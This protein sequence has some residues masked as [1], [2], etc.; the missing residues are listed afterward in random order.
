[1]DVPAIVLCSYL[2]RMHR[3]SGH[4]R[5][6]VSAG[7]VHTD[8]LPERAVAEMEK[9]QRHQIHLGAA[10]KPVIGISRVS[11]LQDRVFTSPPT[12]EIHRTPANSPS[13]SMRFQTRTLCDQWI[14]R[15]IVEV[16]RATP[17][18][19]RPGARP[20]CR[21]TAGRAES[22]IECM[23]ECH[24]SVGVIHFRQRTTRRRGAEGSAWRRLR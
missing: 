7:Q 8:L 9:L 17:H 16:G 15:L 12:Q 22:P 5:R 14:T 4:P 10:S 18:R 21:R 1:M 24:D 23:H 6:R 13:C 3:R 2:P 11:G 20:P 19:S